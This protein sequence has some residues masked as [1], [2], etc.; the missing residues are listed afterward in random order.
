MKRLLVAL[1]AVLI[2]ACAS[3]P[4]PIVATVTVP[5]IKTTTPPSSQQIATAKRLLRAWAYD[6]GRNVLGFGPI[7]A[8]VFANKMSK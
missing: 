8:R 2:A 3:A 6:F 1:V 4:A 7:R 5:A